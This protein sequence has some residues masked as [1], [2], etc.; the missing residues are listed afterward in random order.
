VEWGKEHWDDKRF[1]R[2]AA[3]SIVVTALIFVGLVWPYKFSRATDP[4]LSSDVLPPLI[5]FGLLLAVALFVFGQG[6]VADGD[7]DSRRW[8]TLAVCAVLPVALIAWWAVSL[9]SD[10]AAQA[11]MFRTFKDYTLLIRNGDLLGDP[12]IDSGDRG[13]ASICADG[14]GVTFNGAPRP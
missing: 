9:R 10:H 1:I 3:G 4:R 12:Y 5:G 6:F 7:A 11:D 13:G 2:F 14:P 8:R